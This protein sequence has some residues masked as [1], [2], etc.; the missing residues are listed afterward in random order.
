M[1][2]NRVT[3]AFASAFHREKVADPK[4]SREIERQLKERFHQYV[5][6]ECVLQEDQALT[7]VP[8]HAEDSVNMADA[9]AEIFG[10]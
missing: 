8:A 1:S 2:E 4:A 3:L 7:P 6:V 5:R 9:V 10:R